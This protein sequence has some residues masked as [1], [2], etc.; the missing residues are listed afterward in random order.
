MGGFGVPEVDSVDGLVDVDVDVN[1][2]L[3][4]VGQSVT[5]D[6]SLADEGL[7]GLGAEVGELEVLDRF[8]DIEVFGDVVDVNSG[9]KHASGDY[10]EVELPGVP[11]SHESD[12]LGVGDLLLD[13][14]VSTLAVQPNSVGGFG[15]SNGD[16]VP[17]LSLDS[18]SDLNGGVIVDD[19][20]VLVDHDL[21]VLLVGQVVVLEDGEG[22]SG[23]GGV[24]VEPGGE[25]VSV[26][27]EGLVGVEV[28]VVSHVLGVGA[29]DDLDTLDD[30]D[31][32][33]SAVSVLAGEAVVALLAGDIALGAEVVA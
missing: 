17:L 27:V 1:N 23:G 21:V 14:G 28:E 3:V 8:L 13:D 22:T 15:P 20:L 19:N 31:L 5:F 7:V 9:V 30:A 16:E 2:A 18:S 26:G 29:L 33:G 4:L 10:V 32:G 24:N 12:S 6:A 11:N 25:G